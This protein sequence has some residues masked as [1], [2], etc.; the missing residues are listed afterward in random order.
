M[1]P[2]TSCLLFY[3]ASSRVRCSTCTARDDVTLLQ[4]NARSSSARTW[5]ERALH[6]SAP[7]LQG[8]TARAE[9]ASIEWD[10]RDLPFTV[11]DEAVGN[12]VLE[13]NRVAWSD[14]ALSDFLANVSGQSQLTL[15]RK[16]TLQARNESKPLMW[17]HIHKAGGTLMCKFAK[18]YER[19]IA[20]ADAN[21]NWLWHDEYDQSGAEGSRTPCAE[22]ARV[23][24]EGGFTYGQ[25][26]REMDTNELCDD[27]RYGVMLRD[28]L[29]LIHSMVNYGIWYERQVKGGCPEN[30]E[31]C[32]LRIPGDTATWL[33]DCIRRRSV[34]VNQF[35]TWV[36][37]DNFQ[38]RL[39][40]NAIDVPAGQIGE[41]HVAR[42]RAFLEKNHFTVFLLEDLAKKGD[43]L[44]AQLGWPFPTE[45]LHERPQSLHGKDQ[46]ARPFQPEEISFLRDLN[47]Y[48]YELYESFRMQN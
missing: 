42:A 22:R 12:R 4:L 16:S 13:D 9:A 35:F 1:K 45:G 17:L 47:K 36:W 34:A 3:L 27:F 2:S 26:E 7:P 28:P 20:P 29:S 8:E 46:D 44:F 32:A 19:L 25:V 15:F 21:C 30:P 24:K 6:S 14:H 11:G 31:Y 41:E 18:K 23:W 40:A 5:P 10:L 37:F 39:L 33:Q 48:D 38:T 43:V